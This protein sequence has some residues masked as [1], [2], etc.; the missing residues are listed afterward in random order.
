MRSKAWIFIWF[1]FFIFPE[2]GRSSEADDIQRHCVPVRTQHTDLLD[3]LDL[4]PGVSLAHV[5]PLRVLLSR[6]RCPLE[7]DFLMR[8]AT[9][10]TPETF[11]AL[12]RERFKHLEMVAILSQ[13]PMTIASRIPLISELWR[14]QQEKGQDGADD[15]FHSNIVLVAGASAERL[16]TL[17]DMCRTVKRSLALSLQRRTLM[18]QITRMQPERIASMCALLSGVTRESL[19]DELILHAD[20]S[21]DEE[22]RAIA[23]TSFDPAHLLGD[24]KNLYQEDPSVSKPQRSTEH[25]CA[26]ACAKG[27]D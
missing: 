5:A 19:C 22:L 17:I 11:A 8:K 12:A 15:N 4:R 14:V 7:Q 13:D 26:C 3:V 20:T 25:A 24:I 27:S 21:T 1:V 18:T 9:D 23:R 6:T 16:R 2:L 10:H